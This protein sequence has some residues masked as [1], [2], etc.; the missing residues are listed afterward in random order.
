MKGGYDDSSFEKFL[1]ESIKNKKVETFFSE[2]PDFTPEQKKRMED[3]I[4]RAMDMRLLRRKAEAVNKNKTPAAFILSAREKARLSV[5]RVSGLLKMDE[6]VYESIEKGESRL[7]SLPV[8]SIAGIMTVFHIRLTELA[9]M[10]EKE[11][12]L[13][14]TV[15]AG[16]RATARS[17]H[18]TEKGDRKK[19]ITLGIKAIMLEINKKKKGG[20]AQTDKNNE[21]V[22]RIKKY[23]IEN[24]EADLL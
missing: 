1:L 5:K 22:G 9:R 6:V 3:T 14:D 23:L 17:S 11:A 13:P 2:N 10:L 16:V 12:M 21:M 15:P 8:E 18:K 7:S 19:N 24:D 4:A 20:A